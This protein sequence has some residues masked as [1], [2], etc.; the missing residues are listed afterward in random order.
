MRLS[1][2]ERKEGTIMPKLYHSIY[3]P[4]IEQYVAMQIKLG[5]KPK[6]PVPILAVFDKW[7]LKRNE[8]VVCLSKGLVDEWGVLRVNESEINRYKRIQGVRLFATFLC[9]IG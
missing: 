3:G 2:K 8:K 6:K 9:K 5:Y 1:T 7:I 4:Y